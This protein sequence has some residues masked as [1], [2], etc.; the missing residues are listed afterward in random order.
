[1][2]F[3]PPK[4]QA[5]F[6]DLK[7]I[8]V[9]S[10]K[11]DHALYQTVQIL[12]ERLEQSQ[13]VTIGQ[14]TDLQKAI[15]KNNTSVVSVARN[16]ADATFLTTADESTP[17]PQSRMELAGT[18]IIFDDSVAHRRTIRATGLGTHYDCPLSDGDTSAADLIFANGECIIVQVPV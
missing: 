8:L 17:F 15:E 14:I 11:T 9:Q 7:G 12:I 6:A 16:L 18:G 13:N 5:Q 2:A 3:Q 1:M 10:K 4:K